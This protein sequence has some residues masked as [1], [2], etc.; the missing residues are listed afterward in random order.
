VT[1]KKIAV[2]LSI[3]LIGIIGFSLT[4]SA[5]SS[6]VPDWVKNTALWW[7]EG[8]I[9]EAD[10]L[11]SLEYLISNGIIDVQVPFAQVTASQNL[12][13]EDE[14]AQSFSV[15]FYEGL[16]TEPVTVDTFIK[17]EA[18]SSSTELGSDPETPVYFFKDSPEFLLEGLPSADKQIV[19]QGIHNWMTQSRILNPFDVDVA[20]ISG[21]GA[22]LLTWE[23]TDCRP[24]A[25]GT[26]LQDTIFLYQFVDQERAEIRDRVLFEC[27]GADLRVPEN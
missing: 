18:T 16:I 25:F 5:Q 1:P 2:I 6:A 22:T 15:T 20:V 4:A 19:Y 21:G 17:F 13:S 12:L 7:A 9:T 27:T 8:S 3:S 10:Y 14:R 26:Y 23:F 24:T 11:T